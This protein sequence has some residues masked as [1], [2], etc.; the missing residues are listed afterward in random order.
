[1]VNAL[2]DDEDLWQQ[3][4]E[5]FHIDTSGL[6]MS[7]DHLYH[8]DS[9]LRQF[10]INPYGELKFCLFS[11]KFSASLKEKT[12]E[13]IF[14]NR[15][16]CISQEK[17]KTVSLC[18]SCRLRPICCWCPPKAYIETGNEE[19]PVEYYCRLVRAVDKEA[20]RLQ[21]ASA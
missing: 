12:F 1:M 19:K 17:F 11:D 3:N 13:E 6:Q 14:Y 16:P 10:F 5:G 7:P 4:I 15:I 21:G 18:R 20:K 2:K 8:C 9:W